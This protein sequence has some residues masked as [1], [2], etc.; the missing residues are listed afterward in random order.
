MSQEYSISAAEYLKNVLNTQVET[1]LTEV[2]ANAIGAKVK[3]ELN[4]K[5]QAA[6]DVALGAVK[7]ACSEMIEAAAKDVA[8]KYTESVVGPMRE[9]IITACDKQMQEIMSEVSACSIAHFRERAEIMLERELV[10][11]SVRRAQSSARVLEMF[12]ATLEEDALRLG[13]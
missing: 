2:V 4:A 9:Q 12:S 13:F 6:F 10:A 5:I 8:V 11:A 7:R 3:F 1:Q